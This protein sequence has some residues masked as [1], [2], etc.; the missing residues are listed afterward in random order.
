M[1]VSLIINRSS[2][3]KSLSVLILGAIKLPKLSKDKEDK[4]LPG[5]AQ[6][7]LTKTRIL[8]VWLLVISSWLVVAASLDPNDSNAFPIT[9]P[10][11]VAFIATPGIQ[12]EVR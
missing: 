3:I 1:L 6:P 12:E 10:G 7:T 8:P 9:C 5:S 2:L 4:K 11:R